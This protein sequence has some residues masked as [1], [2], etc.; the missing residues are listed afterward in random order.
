MKLAINRGAD[1]PLKEAAQME[2]LQ[3]SMLSTGS[4]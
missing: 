2:Q 1:L 4:Q 3:A